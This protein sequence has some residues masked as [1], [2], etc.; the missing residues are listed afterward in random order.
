MSMLQEAD[1]ILC[2]S[3]PLYGDDNQATMNA[4]T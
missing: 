1:V 3:L 4:K 2:L